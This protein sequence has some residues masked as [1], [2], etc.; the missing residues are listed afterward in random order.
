MD[1]EDYATAQGF[2]AAGL[3]ISLMPVMGIGGRHPGVVV[4]KVRGPEPVRAVHAAVRR[5]QPCGP[6]AERPSGRPARGG[7]AVAPTRRLGSAPTPGRS[8]HR[9]F[10]SRHAPGS[11]DRR[12]A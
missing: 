1:S 6:R 10:G 5:S 3:G 8:A 11:R 4:R 12:T 2:V 7:S 9:A